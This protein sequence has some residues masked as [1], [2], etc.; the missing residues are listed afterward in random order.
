VSSQNEGGLNWFLIHWWIILH[1]LEMTKQEEEE[2]IIIPIQECEISE[3]KLYTNGAQITRLIKTKLKGEQTVRRE[4]NSIR[5][6]SLEYLSSPMTLLKQKDHS[7]PL[8][9]KYL[10][11]LVPLKK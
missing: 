9:L 6:F 3:V 2:E 10:S 7:I 8:F 5:L 11:V 1:Q 4:R